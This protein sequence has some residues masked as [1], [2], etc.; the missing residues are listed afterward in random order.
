MNTGIVPFSIGFGIGVIL[1]VSASVSKERTE[2]SK[3]EQWCVQDAQT[4]EQVIEC[5]KRVYPWE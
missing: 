4:K 5:Q 3:Y 1:A 2:R